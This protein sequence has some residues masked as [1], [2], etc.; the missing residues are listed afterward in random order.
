VK[1]LRV[2]GAP[3]GAGGTDPGFWTRA[4]ANYQ[5]RASQEKA[6]QELPEL[7]QWTRKFD[8][9]TLRRY[10][11]IAAG[12]DKG[13]LVEKILR[14]FGV[15]SPEAFDR[16]WIQPR[17]SFRRSQSFAVNE[18]NTACGCAWWTGAPSTSP[19]RPS[20]LL[21]SARSPAPSPR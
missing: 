21:R 9:V 7:I 11:I 4:E 2:D 5:A 3:T 10:G 6:Q 14:F 19:S 8:K 16:T 17:V 12:E 20:G 13:T 1:H 15:A 18:P